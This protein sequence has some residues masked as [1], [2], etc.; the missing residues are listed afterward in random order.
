MKNYYH[1]PIREGTGWKLFHYDIPGRWPQRSIKE[2]VRR[3]DRTMTGFKPVLSQTALQQTRNIYGGPSE[4]V[5]RKNKH[6]IVR[7][8]VVLMLCCFVGTIGVAQQLKNS[9]TI[10]NTGVL[11]LKNDPLGLPDTLLGT[12][13]LT[14]A[15]Q[16]LSS[17]KYNNVEL[18]GTGTVATPAGN[19]TLNGSLTI[20]APV[21]LNIT[22]GSIITLGDSL[23][24]SGI[25]KGAIQKSVNLTGS[26]TSSNFGNIGAAI[27]WSPN[28]PGVTNVIRASDSLK[29]GNGNES[30]RRFYEIQPTD[31]TATGSVTFKFYD[32]ELNGHTVSNLQLWRSTD[33]GA[34]WVRHIPVVDTLLRTISK[35]NVPLKGLWTASDTV[36]ALGPLQGGAGIP[37][38]LAQ[39][40]TQTDDPV[41]LTTLDTL[42]VFVADIFGSPVSGVS[43]AFAITNRPISSSGE[44][45]SDSSVMTNADGIASTLFTLGNKVGQYRVEATSPTLN[46]TVRFTASAK[47]GAPQT[48]ASIA[49]SPQ[50][51]VILSQLDSLFT[52]AVT[53]IGGNAVDSATVTFTVDSIPSIAAFGYGVSAA[54]VLTDSAGRASTFLT[55]G[56]KVGTY[57]VKA[58]V[59]G[60]SDSIRFFA[61]ATVGAAASMVRGNGNDQVGTV[62]TSVNPMEISLLDVGANPVPNDTVLFRISSFPAGSD[63]GSLS[64]SAVVTNSL[65]TA[66]SILTLGTR[67]GDYTVS[68]QNSTSG[69]SLTFNVKAKAA[70]A[71]SLA[72][73]SGNNQTMPILSMLADSFVVNVAD[74]FGNPVESTMVRFSIDSLFGNGSGASL[75]ADSMFSNAQ[76]IAS[77]RLTLGS[78]AGLY[79]VIADVNGIPTVT[80]DAN[81]SV[82]AAVA[83]QAVSGSGQSAVILTPLVNQFVLRVNDIG[84]NAV[85]NTPVQFTFDAVPANAAGQVMTIPSTA[86]DGSGIARTTLTLGNK[87]GTYRI[88]ASSPGIPDTFF[89]A[90]A[91]HGAAAAMIP[92][93]GAGQTKPILSPLDVPFTL[94]VVDVGENAVPMSNVQF[95]IVGRPAGDTSAVMSASVNPTDTNGVASSRLTLGSKVGLYTVRASIAA[96]SGAES[97]VIAGKNQK[98]TSKQSSPAAIETTFTAL[99]THGASAAMVKVFGDGQINPTE[100]LLDTA[101]VVSV[102]DIGNNPVPNDTVRFSI[103]SAPQ[104]ATLQAVRDSVVV[105]DSNGIALTYLMLG[106]REGTYGVEAA[107]NN[108]PAA[109]F[110]ASAYVLY[111]DLNKDITVNIAD[112]T[113]FVDFLNKKI[114][115]SSSDSVKADYNRDGMIDTLDITYMRE[116]IL[117]RS[118]YANALPPAIFIGDNTNQHYVSPVRVTKRKTFADAT[119]TF[120]ATPFGLRVNVT[121][122]IPVR[123]I[124]VRVHL[125]DSSINVNNIN[126]LLKRAQ[127]MNSFV[128]T[129]D[130]EVRAVAYNLQNIE[131]EPGVGS[132]FR[133]PKIISADMIDSTEVIFATQS[134]RSERSSVTTVTASPTA[135]PITFR[136]SQNYPNPFNGSTTI[137]YDIPDGTALTK[138]VIQV[139]NI[140]GQTIKTL[141]SEEQDPGRYRITWDGRDQYGKTVSSGVYF[142]RLISKSHVGSR[143]MLYV[144]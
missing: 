141:V 10:T 87:V 100:T 106:T 142:Y 14:G 134:N 46:D 7:S 137:E 103:V 38:S 140:L 66:S 143:K 65:G 47:H 133:L 27:T 40:S 39:A 48:L 120:E 41:I 30:I 20:A 70:A 9:G 54:S 136:L 52:V 111:G 18:I 90:T 1:R 102:R 51:R 76:G 8:L 98:T 109:S 19:I 107:V 91:S 125:K 129:T 144:K 17:A 112:I 33:N 23:N 77:S 3:I 13:Q 4:S 45:L 16:Q 124:E 62:G 50:S 132:V 72:E 22:K 58:K 25:L 63:T 5:K 12:L 110:A 126:L 123:G 86:T 130:N 85:P 43:V 61:T 113:M 92:S 21:T 135:Y 83:M 6:T 32:S 69:G 94:Q 101:F 116:T 89:I 67:A 97:M 79:R 139:Y 37:V 28:A 121:N 11:R 138:T 105:T 88:K 128:S 53:D 80:F 64:S 31:A 15:N 81:A 108:V 44:S 55:L 84:G 74:M 93:A 115:L 26:T 35:S 49:V 56:S 2:G 122:T 114:P 71:A 118:L 59:S 24:E 99:A 60:V 104:N 131:I 117:S 78:R 34:N 75:T 119:T 57:G 29:T 127:M 36:R 68:A 82:G 95:S 96:P 42:K 73:I